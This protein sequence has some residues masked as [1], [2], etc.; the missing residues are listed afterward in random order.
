MKKT[1]LLFL[2][3]T[4]YIYGQVG[5]NTSTPQATLD[6]SVTDPDPNKTN[7]EGILIPRVSRLRTQNMI[8]PIESTLI[9]INNI[10]NGSQTGTTID[11]DQIGFYYF[12]GDKWKKIETDTSTETVNKKI[13]AIVS[14]DLPQVL[15]NTVSTKVLFDGNIE[16][17][18][19]SSLS[20]NSSENELIFPEN[21]VFKITGMIGVKGGKSNTDTNDQPGYITSKFISNTGATTIISTQGYSES[22]TE[23]FDDGGVTNPIM[24]FKTG[25]NGGSISL[26]AKYGGSSAGNS[27][28]YMS[29]APSDK[30]LGTFFLI[31]EL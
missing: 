27:G 10:S 30:T 7:A 29:G 25:D 22:S 5:I 31:E 18:N 1:Y 12:N 11:V 16:G 15:S 8:S 6:I 9:Y 19:T 3:L 14:K 2:L 17:I 23:P 21:S 20:L 28:Y 26:E 13:Y 24:I 4:N